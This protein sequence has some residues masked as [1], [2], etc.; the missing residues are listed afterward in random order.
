MKLITFWLNLLD[1]YGSCNGLMLF[2]DN[3]KIVVVMSRV[4]DFRGHHASI[5][6][7]R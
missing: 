4:D 2:K 1:I 5:L 7:M 3:V 6:P